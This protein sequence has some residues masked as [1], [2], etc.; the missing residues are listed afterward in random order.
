MGTGTPDLAFPLPQDHRTGSGADPR[1]RRGFHTPHPHPAA[2]L[3]RGLESSQ[4]DKFRTTAEFFFWQPTIGH[5]AGFK[6]T[7]ES[8][9]TNVG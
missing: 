8:H 7:E 5:T 6:V 1:E 3:T 4:E 2:G 9:G